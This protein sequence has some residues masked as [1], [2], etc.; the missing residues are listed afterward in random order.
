MG[1]DDNKFL[2]V[3]GQLLAVVVI[4]VLFVV[5]STSILKFVST[6]EEGKI[7]EVVR[8]VVKE[9]RVVVAPPSCDK[10]FP[11]YEDLVKRG[12]SLKLADNLAS[13]G[14]GGE[15]VGS[16]KLVVQIGGKD[17]VAC[18]YLYIRASRSGHP[19]DQKY[20]SVYVNPHEFG[21]H[22]LLGRGILASSNDKYTEALLPLESISYL[23][24]LPFDP[25]AKD[26]RIADWS[27]LLNV[28]SHVTFNIALSTTDRR[29]LV[30]N[31]T[32]AYK[33]WNPTTGEETNGCQLSVNR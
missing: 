2:K 23:P 8:E 20:E 22:I 30:E 14:E 11:E 29:G 9:E 7:R 16:V 18:G 4:G 28:N 27:K 10:T 31:V 5:V 15:F 12:Q 13:H 3:L 26:Y 1:K 32:L 24:G 25:S 6:P 19:L 21:G 17:D 33:C